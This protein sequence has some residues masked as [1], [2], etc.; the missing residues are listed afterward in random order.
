MPYFIYCGFLQLFRKKSN[1]PVACVDSRADIVEF[2]QIVQ[3]REV[4]KKV[5]IKD[6]AHLAHFGQL[7]FEEHLRILTLQQKAGI[8]KRLL[9]TEPTLE[10][11]LDPE[12]QPLDITQFLIPV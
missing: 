8:S 7:V 12:V 5:D 4:V 11:V 3:V 10:H 6:V 9:L 2:E 1:K